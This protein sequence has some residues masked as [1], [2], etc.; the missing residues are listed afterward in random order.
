M[1]NCTESNRAFLWNKEYSGKFRTVQKAGTESIG[2][3]NTRE[4]YTQTIPKASQLKQ[5]MEKEKGEGKRGSRGFLSKLASV[6]VSVRLTHSR[7]FGVV[8]SF[9]FFNNS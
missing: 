3:S 6:L 9:T 4:K 5:E 8:K 2:Q 1:F 7:L